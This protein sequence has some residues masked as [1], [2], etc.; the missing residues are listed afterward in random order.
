MPSLIQL[1][2][3]G[4]VVML[5]FWLFTYIEARKIKKVNP[6]IPIHE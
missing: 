1:V 6:I 2:M 3:P 4:I 5:S